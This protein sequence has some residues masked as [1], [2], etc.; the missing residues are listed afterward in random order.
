MEKIISCI[1]G[2]VPMTKK[3]FEILRRHVLGLLK[4]LEQLKQKLQK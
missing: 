3:E 2:V 4:L 1:K